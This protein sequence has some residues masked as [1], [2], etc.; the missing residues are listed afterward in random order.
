MPFP[1]EF[2]RELL[3]IA[4]PEVM[5]ALKN[6]REFVE[7]NTPWLALLDEHRRNQEELAKP[8]QAEQLQA[9]RILAGQDPET[10]VGGREA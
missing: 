3:L 10:G 8:T 1:T 4:L 2:V 7:L 5:D 9:G 6:G